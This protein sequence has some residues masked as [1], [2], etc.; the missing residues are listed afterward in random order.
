MKNVHLR[1]I[2]ISHH[3]ALK[4]VA[5]NQG[6]SLNDLLLSI[7]A[8]YVGNPNPS[9]VILGYVK[10]DYIGDVNVLD[11]CG[12]CNYPDLEYGIYLAIRGNGLNPIVACHT[13]AQE[14]NDP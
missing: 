1:N 3:K 11:G 14:H 5:K 10:L 8:D 13:C 4:K 2:P 9:Q 7:V 6:K 12:I